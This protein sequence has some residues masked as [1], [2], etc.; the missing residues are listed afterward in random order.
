MLCWIGIFFS[1]LCFSSCLAF[2]LEN[3]VNLSTWRCIQVFTKEK[4][5]DF[6]RAQL[7]QYPASYFN[8][9]LGEEGVSEA[10][11][12]LERSP[13]CLVVEDTGDVGVRAKL[14]GVEQGPHKVIISII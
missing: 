10:L 3:K 2:G 6:W 13:Q 11:D 4:K 5:L 7:K 9:R 8:I 14:A 12:G 1:L